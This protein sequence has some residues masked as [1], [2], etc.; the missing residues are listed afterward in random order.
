L[1]F[2]LANGRYNP[3]QIMVCNQREVENAGQCSAEH[4]ARMAKNQAAFEASQRAHVNK[5]NAINDSIT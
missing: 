3:Q 1:I 2:A 5:A 4:N